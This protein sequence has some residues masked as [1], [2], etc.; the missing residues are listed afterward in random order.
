VSTPRH[1]VRHSWRA[2]GLYNLVGVGAESGCG[3][4]REA[5]GTRPSGSTRPTKVPFGP[6][7]HVN[8]IFFGPMGTERGKHSS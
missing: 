4:H 1:V 2:T 5:T 8:S 7:G 6:A 3:Q